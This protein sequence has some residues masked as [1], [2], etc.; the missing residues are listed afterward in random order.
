M[1][2]R[3]V[4]ARIDLRPAPVLTAVMEPIFTVIGK[5]DAAMIRSACAR[6]GGPFTA[7]FSTPLPGS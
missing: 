6:N 5:P 1:A 3:V 4:L 7:R 2:S